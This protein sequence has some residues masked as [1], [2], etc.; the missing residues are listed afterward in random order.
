MT[1]RQL[2]ENAARDAAER[3]G[4]LIQNNIDW[5]R[6]H[7]YVAYRWHDVLAKTLPRWR[8]A[9]R[10]YHRMMARRMWALA[11]AKKDAESVKMAETHRKIGLGP[12][13][14]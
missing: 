4:A 14:V 6:A 5:H 10:A 1:P 9:A 3:I 8:W 13:R 11:M 2:A 12:V 7:P